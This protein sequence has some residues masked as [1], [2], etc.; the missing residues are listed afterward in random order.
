MSNRARKASRRRQIQWPRALDRRSFIKAA[1]GA[2]A[3]TAMGACSGL[4]PGEGG[5]TGSVQV[6]VSG[7]STAAAGSVTVT[8]PDGTNPAVTIPLPDAE[9][10]GVSVGIAAGVPVGMYRITYAPP[11]G[12]VVTDPADFR[13]VLVVTDQTITADFAVQAATTGALQVQV[14]GFG[15]AAASAGTVAI[16]QP[17]GTPSGVSLVLPPPSGG[18]SLGSANHPV[19]PHRVTYTPP[20]NHAIAAGTS[21]SEDVTVPGGGTVRAS[22]QVQDLGPP[23]ALV[24]ASDWGTA[25]GT[26]SNAIGD[27][28]KWPILDN[29]A[30]SVA[31]V[32]TSG[33]GFPS[34]MTNVLRIAYDSP[35]ATGLG[36][37]NGWPLPAIGEFLARRYCIRSSV[38]VTGDHHPLQS[39]Y[40]GGTCPYAAEINLFHRAAG[41]YNLTP[42]HKSDGQDFATVTW[43]MWDIDTDLTN[44]VVYQVE[45]RFERITSS[46]YHYDIRIWNAAGTVILFNNSNFNDSWNGWGSLAAVPRPVIT[47]KP[48][49]GEGD[50]LRHFFIVNQGRNWGASQHIHYGGFA[51]LISRNGSWCGPYAPGE[52]D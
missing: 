21:D 38:T 49:S 6:R 1:G 47:I 26:S 10:N 7:L 42:T 41:T 15:A 51:V 31:V 25:A 50:C 18:E 2:V 28:G 8:R 52:A 5:G 35:D 37:Q 9:A 33:L 14:L 22:F 43:Y 30:G 29:S 4:P 24:F 23:P 11:A 3:A 39:A 34:G 32:S 20:A 36:I 46:T 27:G 19:G 17:D 48:V 44:D 16:T 40:Q 13:D 45:E 12:H